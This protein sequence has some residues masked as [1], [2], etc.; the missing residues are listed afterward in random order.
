MSHE[1]LN[2]TDIHTP[3]EHPRGETVPERMGAKPLIEAAS[4]A[5][6]LEGPSGAAFR[7]MREDSPTGKEPMR[8][9]VRLPDQAEHRQQSFRQRQ[10]SLLIAL[11]D[12]PQNHLPGIHGGHGERDRFRHSKTIGI[13]Q[14]EAAAINGLLQGPD[15]AAAIGIGADVRQPLAPGLANFFFVN[16]GQS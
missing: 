7:E 6:F 9:F 2:Q 10:R 11:P 13:H 1:D 12:H 15:Q 14:R 5:G 8:A 4:G 3:F 16:N